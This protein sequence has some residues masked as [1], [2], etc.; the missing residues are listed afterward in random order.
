MDEE[1]TAAAKPPEGLKKTALGLLARRE[2]SRLDLAR[3]LRSRGYATEAIAEVLDGLLESEQLSDGR[4]AQ[5]LV[6]TRAAR[7]FGPRR[8]KYE[9]REHGID[10][11]DCGA[12]L[13]DVADW[14]VV[15]VRAY[16]KKYA[17]RPIVDLKERARRQRF[18]ESRGFEYDQIRAALAE[19][20]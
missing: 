5:M 19:H 13:R 10:E 20:E 1:L 8:I 7:G 4:F 3:K 15:A 18:L 12:A 2:H 14:C 9:L 16:H 6:R 17:D 11:V